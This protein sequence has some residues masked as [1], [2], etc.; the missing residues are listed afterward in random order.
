[1]CIITPSFFIKI[2]QTVWEI[3]H[4]TVFKMAAVSGTHAAGARFR[5]GLIEVDLHGTFA[6]IDMVSE[7]VYRRLLNILLSIGTTAERR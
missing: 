5:F 2:G 3:L 6:I 1:M 4:L 7:E